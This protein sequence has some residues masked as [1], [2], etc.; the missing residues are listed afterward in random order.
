MQY[1]DFLNR[2][3]DLSGLN[4]W[5]NQ[6]TSCGANQQCREAKRTN[7]SA[8]FFLSIE[9]QETG[10]LVYRTHKVAFGSVAGGPTPVRYTDFLPDTQQ[11]GHDVVVNEDGWEQTLEGNKQAYM[12]DFVQRS[13]F[14]SQYPT[15]MTPVVF[16]DALF[17][18]AGI[19]PTAVERSNAIAQFSNQA[20]TTDI[21]A[22]AKALRLIAENKTLGEQEFNKAFV[23][24]QYFGYLRRNPNDAP[25]LGL[26]FNG[27]NFWLNKLNQFNGDFAK[28]DMVK[29]F[30]VSGEYRQRFGP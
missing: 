9:F 10:Y 5:M 23:L 6:I 22:R 7:V 4:F 29:S 26:N 16:V 12:L 13:Q 27:Y 28:A 15:S 2:E 8:A 14:A 1:H 20:D 17:S 24:M 11:I 18:H 3:P 19:V 30:L 25:E 21:P